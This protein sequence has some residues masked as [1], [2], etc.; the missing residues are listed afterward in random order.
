MGAGE[1]ARIMNA[2]ETAYNNPIGSLIGGMASLLQTPTAVED[3]EED[4]EGT[5]VE[6]HTGHHH[7]DLS[8]TGRHARRR[9]RGR[10]QNQ[11]KSEE[12]PEEDLE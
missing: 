6:D 9:T 3:V 12:T 1:G 5:A 4:S 2:I 10:S 11:E 8:Q 7:L